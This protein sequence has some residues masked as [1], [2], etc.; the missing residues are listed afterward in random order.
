MLARIKTKT[1]E[2]AVQFQAAMETLSDVIRFDGQGL[3]Q[4][5]PF[6]WKLLILRQRHI[7]SLFSIESVNGIRLMYIERRVKC[8]YSNIVPRPPTMIPKIFTLSWFTIPKTGLLPWGY[9]VLARYLVDEEDCIHHA[10]KEF[11]TQK[12]S[13]RAIDTT[14]CLVP[15][16]PIRAE[17]ASGSSLLL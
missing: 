16:S 12:C 13:L 4:G 2:A 5:M 9:P 15:E 3:G 17:R 14:D 1:R 11:H 6:I 8:V 10:H 7:I